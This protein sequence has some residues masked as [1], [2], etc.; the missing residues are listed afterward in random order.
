MRVSGDGTPI[1]AHYLDPRLVAL[2]DI[3]NCGR[4]DIDFYLAL[5]SRLDA[6]RIVDI[7]CGTGV[8]A[9]DL[10]AA[11]GALA[12]DREVTGVDPG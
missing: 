3:E 10:A 6:R 11:G 8:L 4:E 9:T 5:A 1:D 2:Y 12:A 7:G